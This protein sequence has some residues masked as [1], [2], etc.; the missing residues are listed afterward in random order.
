M[1][2]PSWLD[3][4]TAAFGGGASIKIIDYL[5]GELRE[6][7]VTR[8]TVKQFVDSHLDPVLKTADELFGKLRDLAIRDFAD[9]KDEHPPEDEP[10]FDDQVE[11]GA[12]LYLF[13]H[14][15]ARIAILRRDSLFVEL[16]R[17]QQGLR[18][19]IFVHGLE[20][21]R[22]RIVD[23]ARQRIIGEALLK[24]SSAG[25][26]R[27]CMTSY[28]FLERYVRDPEFRR[29]FDPLVAIL[30]GTSHTSMRQRLLLYGIVVHAMIDT[31]D[32][33]YEIT[34]DRPAY[35]HK[36]TRR[37]ARDLK[38]RVFGV[39]LSFVKDPAKYISRQTGGTRRQN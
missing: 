28:E 29:W 5:W 26:P 24:E 35:A 1:P 31:L 9:F 39:Y 4:L 8:R 18:L 6:R 33:K 10:S 19:K 12:T 34:T 13:A 38:F 2:S 32:P 25:R 20:S 36:L 7:R 15:W 23:R 3:L 27:D 22:I 14:F 17:N 16:G 21:R 37:T 11:L 30:A